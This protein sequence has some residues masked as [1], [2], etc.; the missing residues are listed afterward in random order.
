MLI[1]TLSLYIASQIIYLFILRDSKYAHL[2]NRVLSLCVLVLFLFLFF[3]KNESF[4]SDT[5]N[6]IAEFKAF[7][8]GGNTYT[9]VDYSYRLVFEL[10][11]VLM[12]GECDYEYLMWVWPIFLVV[13]IYFSC[14]LHKVDVNYTIVIFSSFIGLEL[15]TNA[16]RQG[17]SIAFLIFSVMA[18]KSKNWLGF[19]ISSSLSVCF[20]QSSLLIL[21]V[22]ILSI[23]NYKIFIVSLS[24]SIG[25]LFSTS[26]LDFL[27]SAYD[28]KL[29]ILRYMPLSEDDMIIRLMAIVNMAVTFAIY[30]FMR[31]GNRN[32]SFHSSS[33]NIFI[34]CA[35][36]SLVPYFGFRV[37]YGLYPVFVFVLYSFFGGV[38]EQRYR[39]IAW[40]I[41]TNALIAI[42]WLLGS[43]QM[44]RTDFIS[45]I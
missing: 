3:F 13:L 23:I 39:F 15:L 18:F 30:F 44:R 5:I 42:L 16:M 32:L 2:S 19:L 37:I 29:A 9:G 40:L 14:V 10:I 25:L 21:V 35:F 6:Y 45:F 27:S 20:H 11:N 4:G 26:Y 8:A 17:F 12:L 41:I 1:L 31:R 34:V 7:C 28:F 33:L 43:E 38:S 22:F 36:S 24:I